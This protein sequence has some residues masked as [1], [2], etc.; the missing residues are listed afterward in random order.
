MAAVASLDD[1]QLF[2]NIKP[3]DF[4]GPYFDFTSITIV[5]D[6]LDNIDG[7][8]PLAIEAKEVTTAALSKQDMFVT[9]TLPILIAALGLLAV[10]GG[11]YSRLDDS[12]ASQRLEI[13]GDFQ[14]MSDKLDANVEAV[15]GLRADVGRATGEITKAKSEV[16]QKLSEL[17]SRQVILEAKAKP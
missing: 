1:F 9:V 10:A 2:T 15:G 8:T 6:I 11:M 13:K 5:L 3:I 16:M 7:S 12:I 14:R 17:S 4:V